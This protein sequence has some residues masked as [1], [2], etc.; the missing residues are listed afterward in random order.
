M[1]ASG[2]DLDA[3]SP[4]VKGNYLFARAMIGRDYA[5]PEVA[6]RLAH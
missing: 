4:R 5:V 1:T 6:P 2:P 3:L